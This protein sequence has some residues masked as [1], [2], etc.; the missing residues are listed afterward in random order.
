MGWFL[1]LK[2]EKSLLPG[3]VEQ[4]FIYLFVCLVGWLVCWLNFPLASRDILNQPI[5]DSLL[6]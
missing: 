5:H 6:R 3:N 4:W 1:F 2:K